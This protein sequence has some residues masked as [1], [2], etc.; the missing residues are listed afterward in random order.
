ME[1]K[2]AG[3]VSGELDGRLS[4]P[5]QAKPVHPFQA[6]RMGMEPGGGHRHR[7]AG[8]RSCRGE[9]KPGFGAGLMDVQ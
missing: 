4:S 1:L 2:R 7:L 3:K 8:I 5:F 9:F 6:V